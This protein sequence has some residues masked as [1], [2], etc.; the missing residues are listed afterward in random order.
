MHPIWVPRSLNSRPTGHL[1]RLASRLRPTFLPPPVSVRGRG[2]FLFRP[3]RSGK[4][5]RG[6]GVSSA[7]SSARTGGPLWGLRREQ[8]CPSGGR[9]T[10]SPRRWDVRGDGR[11]LRYVLRR[12]SGARVQGHLREKFAS[13]SDARRPRLDCVGTAVN[14]ATAVCR[15]RTGFDNEKYIAQQAEHIRTA[16]TSSTA[17]C[18]SNSAESSSTTTMQPRASRI[19]ARHQ[20]PHAESLSM[21]SRSSSP[22]TPTTSRRTRPAAISASPTTKTAAPI[23]HLPQRPFSSAPW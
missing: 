3:L 20:D 16:S 6:R 14:N 7:A 8:D 23:G 17:S 13:A 15:M 4:P 1:N 21:T 11:P 18:T 9:Y 10:P 5:T 2:R 22:S 12:R 19:R